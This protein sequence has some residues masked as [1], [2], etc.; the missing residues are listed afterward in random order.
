ML[1]ATPK[2]DFGRVA[3]CTSKNVKSMSLLTRLVSTPQMEERELRHGEA[4][5]KGGIPDVHPL[6]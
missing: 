4:L 1:V 2:G 6:F 5:Y 3:L